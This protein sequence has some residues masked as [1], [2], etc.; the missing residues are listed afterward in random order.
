[1]R[2]L[3]YHVWMGGKALRWADDVWD[4][5]ALTDGDF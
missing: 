5:E 3:D 4:L 2:I 1:M